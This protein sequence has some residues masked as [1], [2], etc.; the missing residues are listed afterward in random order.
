MW[1]D[2]TKEYNFD[3]IFNQVNRLS[4]VQTIWGTKKDYSFFNSGQEGGGG[5]GFLNMEP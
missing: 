2:S 5:G 4:K 1:H 3:D